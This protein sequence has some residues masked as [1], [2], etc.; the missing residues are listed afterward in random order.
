MMVTTMVSVRIINKQWT[1][2]RINEKVLKYCE[3]KMKIA[4]KMAL[5]RLISS[6][7]LIKKLKLTRISEELIWQ[8]W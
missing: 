4:I 2:T 3:L 8:W 1:L 6:T 5:M 7:W